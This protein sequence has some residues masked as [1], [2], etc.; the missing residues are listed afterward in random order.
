MNITYSKRPEDWE[1]VHYISEIKALLE[2]LLMSGS[3]SANKW[4]T[5][6][7]EKLLIFFLDFYLPTA[8]H[9]IYPHERKIEV[10]VKNPN[11]PGGGPP[12]RVIDYKEGEPFEAITKKYADAVIAF[13]QAELKEPLANARDV[14]KACS[15]YTDKRVK[16]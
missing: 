4:I 11:G 13:W 14:N 15:K 9:S 7:Q 2:R 3:K 10:Y 8:Y 6:Y 16:L 5:E 1:S 12:Y